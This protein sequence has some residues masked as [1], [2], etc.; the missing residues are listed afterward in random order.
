MNGTPDSVS[1][2]EQFEV[3]A[4]SPPAAVCLR[5]E[6]AGSC[7]LVEGE[8]IPAEIVEES[9]GSVSVLVARLFHAEVNEPIETI[10]HGLRL[11]GRIRSIA[12]QGKRMRLE[13]QWARRERRTVDEQRPRCRTESDYVL[14]AGLPVACRVVDQSDT[15]LTAVLPDGTEIRV[16]AGDVH[17]VNRFQ[18]LADL[19]GAEEELRLLTALYQLGATPSAD[20][21]LR[22]IL[23]LEFAPFWE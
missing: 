3:A 5:P 7:L 16:A 20:D 14:L 4:G 11:S 13:I 17:P 21:A 6:Q 2:L 12:S 1:L 9:F 15:Q 18:R 22:D 10:Y 8:E 23:N 19:E